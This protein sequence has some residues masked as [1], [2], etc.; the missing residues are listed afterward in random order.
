MKIDIPPFDGLFTDAEVREVPDHAL[1]YTK[2]S[3]SSDTPSEQDD[4]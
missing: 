3:G 4:I 1:L 2:K